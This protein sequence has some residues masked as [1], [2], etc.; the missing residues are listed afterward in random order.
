MT[1][2]DKVKPKLSEKVFKKVLKMGSRHPRSPKAN[3]RNIA[4]IFENLKNHPFENTTYL[5]MCTQ[6]RCA[7]MKMTEIANKQTDKQTLV[8]FEVWGPE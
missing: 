7:G 3:D 2:Y 5:E 8:S 6:W 1:S 4:I